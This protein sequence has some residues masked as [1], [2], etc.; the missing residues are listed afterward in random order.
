MEKGEIIVNLFVNQ[1]IDL[2]L[3]RYERVVCFQN[4]LRSRLALDVEG[5]LASYPCRHCMYGVYCNYQYVQYK[6]ITMIRRPIF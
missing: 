4:V 5:E 6:Y 3:F 2:M 1:R